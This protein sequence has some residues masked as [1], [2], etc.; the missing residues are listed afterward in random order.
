MHRT[1]AFC[2][3]K[4]IKK[5][6]YMPEAYGCYMLKWIKQ[7]MVMKFLSRFMVTLNNKKWEM[8]LVH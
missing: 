3:K 7:I 5:Q 1:E 6:W 8:L 4:K 2:P